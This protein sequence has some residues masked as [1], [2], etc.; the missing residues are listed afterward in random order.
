MNMTSTIKADWTLTND[1]STSRTAWIYASTKPGTGS[2]P[3]QTIQR[4]FSHIIF[5]ESQLP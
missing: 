3:E 1:S 4:A 2:T 5:P